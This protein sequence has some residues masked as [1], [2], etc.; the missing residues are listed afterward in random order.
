MQGFELSHV[1]ESFP[2]LNQHFKGVYAINTLPKTLKY[3][4][5][6]ICNTDSSYGSGIHWF[7]FL[8]NSK[9]SIE[10]FDSLGISE[11]KREVLKSNC[12]FRGVKEIIFNETQFQK[13]SSTS[14][15][16]FVI[17]F[18]FE[19]MHNLD[20]SFETTLSEIFDP[21]NEESN[22]RT[23]ALFCNNLTN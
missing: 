6:C 16:L 17:Y 2:V 1:I 13:S 22:E 14:C 23:V 3:R 5:F 18:I 9:T 7:C 10:C 15:G 11:T 4:Q 21:N 20:L 12:Y 19:R 8:R